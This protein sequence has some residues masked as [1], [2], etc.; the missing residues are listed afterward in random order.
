[1]APDIWMKLIIMSYRPNGLLTWMNFELDIFSS[2]PL[3]SAPLLWQNIKYIEVWLATF[4]ATH[5]IA[6]VPAFLCLNGD[7]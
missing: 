2:Q 5:S 4:I 6:F 7:F 3:H 1:M